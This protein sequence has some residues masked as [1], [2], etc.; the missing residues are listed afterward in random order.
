MLHEI[1]YKLKTQARDLILFVFV[2]SA[3]AL[4]GGFNTA[5]AVPPHPDLKAK[6]ESGEIAL[7]P[8]LKNY[9]ALKARGVCGSSISNAPGELLKHR[10]Q[11]AQSG[12]GAQPS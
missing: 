11:S 4:S 9:S 1:S 10:A 5:Q 7:P 12:S 2:T 6:I 3:F 8:F